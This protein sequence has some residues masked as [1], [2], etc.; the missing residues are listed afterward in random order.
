MDIKKEILKVASI[1]IGVALGG[2]LL[3]LAINDNQGYENTIELLA[4]AFSIYVAFSIFGMTW[5][6]YGKSKNNHSLFMGAAFLVIGF[7]D[8][9]H[10]LS[11]VFMPDF[12]TPNVAGKSDIFWNFARIISAPLFLASAYIYNDTLPAWINKTVLSICAIVITA[13]SFIA[14][15]FFQSY[16]MAYYT[17]EHSAFRLIQVLITAII[18]LYAAYLYTQRKAEKNTENYLIYGFIIVVFSDLIYFYYEVPAHLLKIAGFYFIYLSLYKFSVELPYDLL[19]FAEEKLRNAAEEKYRN[20][21]DNAND[22]IIIHDTNG[23]VTSWNHAAEKIF[24]WTAEEITGKKLAPMI[25]PEEYRA[26]METIMRKLESGG[27]SYFEPEFLRKDGTRINTSLTV[28]YLKDADRNVIGISCIIRDI[29]EHKKAEELRLENE[30]LVL[31]NIAKSE[32]LDTMSH[33]LRTPL[34]SVIGFAML[35][36]QKVAGNLNVKQEKYVDNILAGGMHQLNLVDMILDVTSLEAGK[37]ELNIKKIS[38]PDTIQ[39]VLNLI[40]EQAAQLNVTVKNEI[41]PALDYI[42]ADEKMFR[43]ILFNLLDNA[44]KFSKP[45]GG[46]VTITCR[47]ADNMARFSVSDTGIGIREEDMDKL[48]RTFQQVDTGSTRKYG[49]T[50]IGLAIAKQLVELHGGTITAESRVGEGSTFTFTLP[51]GQKQREKK[52][53][54]SVS[55]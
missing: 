17:G 35:L 34:N 23:I 20:L 48:F 28:S 39:Q 53:D 15:V 54:K 36:K 10:V 32:F 38:V 18:I 27:S 29:T 5:D 9:L 25:I 30:R 13:T 1:I 3:D 33:E 6:S 50:G 21:F 26:G 55:G 41:D 16:F 4:E 7:I 49:G 19:A 42:Y 11:Y 46:I 31:A 43:H 8:L 40:M 52:Y 2:F 47:K 14:G 22:A 45:E 44:V 24:G 51:V 37:L 12:I